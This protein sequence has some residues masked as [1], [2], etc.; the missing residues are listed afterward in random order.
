[1]VL[2]RLSFITA[3]ITLSILL[4][5][6]S[7]SRAPEPM[8]QRAEQTTIDQAHQDMME[9]AI[10]LLR[11][12]DATTAE[13]YLL[14]VVKAYPGFAPALNNLALIHFQRGDIATAKT[15]NDLVLSFDSPSAETLNL[16][17][18]IA[19]EMGAYQHAQQHYETALA[20]AG[21]FANAHYNL[22]LLYDIYFQD[23]PKAIHHYERYLSAIPQVD[24]PVQQ[25][26]EELKRNVK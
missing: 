25:W 24:E 3:M 26:V 10:A 7:T 20:K 4:G 16:A 17:G 11:N 14:Q 15:Y 5:C 23:L 1:M 13:G 8:A 19:V 18:L 2:H 21:S 6:A 22:A 9:R 12:N